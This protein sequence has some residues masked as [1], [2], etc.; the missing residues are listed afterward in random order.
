VSL[1]EK[2]GCLTFVTSKAQ[3]QSLKRERQGVLD[4]FMGFQHFAQNKVRSRLQKRLLA[5]VKPRSPLAAPY[6]SRPSC[7]TRCAIIISHQKGREKLLLK[8]SLF[9]YWQNIPAAAIPSRRAGRPAPAKPP[10]GRN[11]ARI[12]GRSGVFGTFF[13]NLVNVLMQSMCQCANEAH[14]HIEH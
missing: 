11:A 13:L 8:I 9:A 5:C 7:E 4:M 3:I 6:A 10:Q 14:W 2:T 12:C 1:A